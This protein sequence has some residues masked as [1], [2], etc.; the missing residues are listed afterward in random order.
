MGK[1]VVPNPALGKKA[2]LC[3]VRNVVQHCPSSAGKRACGELVVRVQQRDGQIAGWGLPVRPLALVQEGVEALGQAAEV[4]VKIWR[5]NV[6]K[7]CLAVAH[8]RD[9]S[10]KTRGQIAEIRRGARTCLFRSRRNL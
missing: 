8:E 1:H 4:A 2:G 6:G 9:A 7:T 3:G 5:L 10:G